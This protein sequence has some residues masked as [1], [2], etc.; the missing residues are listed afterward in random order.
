MASTEKAVETVTVKPQGK[1][2]ATNVDEFRQELLALV[3]S[4]SVDLLI[5]LADVDMIDSK[6]LAVFIVCQKKIGRASCR[7]RV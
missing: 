2:T 7:E 1:I 3:E 4:G 6:G 5:D